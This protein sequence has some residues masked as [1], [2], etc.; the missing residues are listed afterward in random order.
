MQFQH[1]GLNTFFA[2]FVSGM[3][4][5]SVRFFVSL[6]KVTFVVPGKNTVRSYVPRNERLHYLRLIGGTP[7][8]SQLRGGFWALTIRLQIW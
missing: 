6:L 5:D 3:V 2:R 8:R 1:L 4:T 7:W